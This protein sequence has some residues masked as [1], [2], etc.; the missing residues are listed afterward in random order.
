MLSYERAQ[1]PGWAVTGFF[2]RCRLCRHFEAGGDRL[3]PFGA[4]CNFGHS[5]AEIRQRQS[6]PLVAHRLR[7]CND[8]A[9][10]TIARMHVRG[11]SNRAACD[12]AHRFVRA[13]ADSRA[14]LPFG[15][16]EVPRPPLPP[17]HAHAPSHA[18]DVLIGLPFRAFAASGKDA[19]AAAPEGRPSGAGVPRR[20]GAD[21]LLE[22]RAELH[23][24][25]TASSDGCRA[26]A[27]PARNV[28]G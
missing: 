19:A 14:S 20:N 5:D 11:A 18:T 13:E 2:R 27:S 4:H 15:W 16:E 1:R 26:T 28:Y 10:A 9:H 22:S 17:E 25:G 21:L 6:P 7:A 24:V 3:C 23:G 12:S 8:P